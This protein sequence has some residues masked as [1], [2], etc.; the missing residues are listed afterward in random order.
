MHI[1]ETLRGGGVFLVIKMVAS[2]GAYGLA[3]YVSRE[4]G[5]EGNGVLA[6]ALTAAVLLAAFFNLGLNTY[7]VKMIQVLKARGEWT[8]MHRFYRKALVTIMGTTLVGCGVLML[9]S[10]VISD[11]T[12]SRDLYLVSWVTIPVSIMLFISHAYKGQ[13]RI[14]GFSLLQNNVIQVL[15]LFILWLPFW[16][17]T[18][19]SEP[20]WAV[21]FAG[22]MLCVVGWW[23]YGEPKENE[24]D[25]EFR[26]RPHIREALPMLAGGLAFMV[27]NLTDRMMLRFLDTTTQLGIYDVS[28]R[29]SNLALLGI[30]SLNTVAEPKFAHFFAR[31]EP[32]QLKQ[33][34]G[35]MTWIG[36]GISLPVLGTLALFPSFWLGMFGTGDEFLAGVPSLY[37]LLLGQIISVGCGAVLVLLNMTGHQRDVQMILVSSALLNIGLNFILIPSMSIDGAALATMASTLV[38]N[39][40]GLWVIR[41]KLGFWMWGF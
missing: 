3:W 27:L 36:I 23:K 21:T 25:A 1:L 18:S 12:F 29:L 5:A 9:I 38:W 39:L 22:S 32:L 15:A 7:I 10:T 6:F 26:F 34:V 24:S 37:A 8:G 17:N 16:G 40:W 19:V 13:Q 14:L 28:L 35:R 2:L 41:K 33:F 4:Y 11:E 30:L 20:V 31:N